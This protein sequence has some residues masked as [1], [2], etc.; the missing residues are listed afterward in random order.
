MRFSSYGSAVFP[1]QLRELL[2]DAPET[3]DSRRRDPKASETSDVRL[4]F[5]DLF[6]V[7]WKDAKSVLQPSPT[8]VIQNRQLPFVRRDNHFSADFVRDPVL[9]AKCDHRAVAL[10]CKARLETTRLVINPGV[11]DAAVAP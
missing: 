6:P 4:D 3:Y 10:A 5:L 2:A 1:D 8:E 11:D 9:L 7:N